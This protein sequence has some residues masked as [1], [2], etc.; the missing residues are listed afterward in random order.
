[1]HRACDR[2]DGEKRQEVLQG[3]FSS[4]KQLLRRDDVK[5]PAARAGKGGEK[6][7]QGEP[8]HAELVGEA[9]DFGLF[10]NQAEIFFIPIGCFMLQRGLVELAVKNVVEGHGCLLVC[11]WKHP[12]PLA[13]LVLS[14]KG[15]T[16]LP[17]L[18][19]ACRANSYGSNS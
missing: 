4:E 8:I 6:S 17:A 1:M 13:R 10:P 16:S 19:T 11:L 9:L 3:I 18:L 2:Q 5:K 15:S 12:A 7:V 14:G